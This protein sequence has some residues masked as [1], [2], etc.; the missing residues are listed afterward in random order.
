MG[1]GSRH[2]TKGQNWQHHGPNMGSSVQQD[3]NTHH[4]QQ[5]TFE[6]VKN[7]KFYVFQDPFQ[8]NL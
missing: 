1:I 4:Q 3:G 7:A 6:K 8:P 2:K 5:K